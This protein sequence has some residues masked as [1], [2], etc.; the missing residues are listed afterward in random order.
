MSS[1]KKPKNNGCLFLVAKDKFL[2]MRSLLVRPFS[3]D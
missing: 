1:F 2:P 3:Y